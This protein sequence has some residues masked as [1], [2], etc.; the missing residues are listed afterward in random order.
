MRSTTYG[1][2][3]F[4]GVPII[5]NILLRRSNLKSIPLPDLRRFL[6]AGGALAAENVR[7]DAADRGHCGRILRHVWA[8]R[9]D[10]ANLL[11]TVQ[12]GLPDKLGSAGLALDNLE[13]RDCR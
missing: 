3:T 10:G 2:T 6:Q 13:L 8:D 7:A 12:P 11:P 9:S 4:A 5:Y 1:C